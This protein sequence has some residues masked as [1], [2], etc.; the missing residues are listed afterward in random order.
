MHSGFFFPILP[1][2]SPFASFSHPKAEED[3]PPPCHGTALS[4]TGA[5]SREAERKRKT[6]RE[7]KL[8][9]NNIFGFNS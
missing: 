5:T 7:E 6:A 3:R 8:C 2:F 4:A 1:L 9:V